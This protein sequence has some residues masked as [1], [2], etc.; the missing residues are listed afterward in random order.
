M[1]DC[2]ETEKNRTFVHNMNAQRVQKPEEGNGPPGTGGKILQGKGLISIS[3]ESRAK[4][5]ACYGVIIVLSVA[6]VALS[7]ALSGKKTEQI[8]IKNTYAACPR[9]WIG[10]GNKC[11][12]F[13]EYTS[14]WT[15][16]QAFCM[17]QDAQ[18]AQFDN[19]DELNFLMRYTGNFDCWIGLHRES[20]EHAWKWTDNTEY[21]NMTLIQGEERYA[22]LN[23][24]GISSSRIYLPRMSI[25]SKLNNYSLHSQTPSPV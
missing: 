3:R 6:I 13:S 14:N 10:I 1:L 16:A 19:Q 2:L 11:F 5:Y 8:T 7:V 21:N 17:A 25:C 12:Y 18:L 20:S 15:S 9:H 22:Y 4:L 23:N 24:N